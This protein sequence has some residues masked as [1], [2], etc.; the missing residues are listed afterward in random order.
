[1]T[2]KRAVVIPF[3]VPSEGRGLGIGLAALVHGFVQV[4]GQNVA[5]AQVHSR[6]PAS[7]GPATPQPVE[8]FVP[9]S[10][11]RDLAGAGNAPQG[12]AVV[13]TGA[14]EPP[15]DGRGAIQL[16]AFDARDGATRAAVESPLDGP[17]A[18]A[19]LIA[20]FEEL[21]GKIG[22]NLGAVKDIGDLEWDA[23]ESVLLAERFALHDPSRGG[24]NDR[25]AAMGHLGR[26]VFDAPDAR[27]PA[28][29]L[30]AMALEA[31]NSQPRDPKLAKA[32]LRALSRASEDA[33][34]NLDLSE[35][36]AAL[37]TRTGD[38]ASAERRLNEALT[39]APK[40]P[41]LYALLAETLRARGAMDAAMAAIESG[42]GAAPRDPVLENERGGLLALRGD[43]DDAARAWLGVLDRGMSPPAFA[44]AAA[45]A[46]RRRDTTLAQSLVDRALAVNDVPVD[47][48]RRAIQLALASEPDGIARATRV[49]KLARSIG[50]SQP[51][52]AWAALVLARATTQ[53][54]QKSEARDLLARVETHAPGTPMAAEAQRARFAIEEPDAALAIE[55]TL[56]A[57]GSAPAKDLEE[58][59]VR[60][61]RLAISHGG[62]LGWLAASVAERRAG[63]FLAAR[64]AANSALEI[65]PG[66]SPAHAELA[67][68]AI[69]LGDGAR[70]VLHAEKTLALEGEQP[71]LVALLARA[72]AAAGRRDEAIAVAERAARL[73]PN[74]EA[75]KRVAEDI[76]APP[77]QR[78]SWFASAGASV[79]K[80]L[81]R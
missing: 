42:L 10:A 80:L 51:D 15:T 81:R 23:L 63:R 79:K 64:E 44:N 39:R 62:W 4:D 40:R 29:R 2:D 67:S 21:C 37:E 52:D 33:P 74:D 75:L 35:A 70:A 60:A 13:L 58:I 28:G 68:V 36:M 71:R 12:I 59:A 20:A 57:A 49:A 78:A 66:C 17:H 18:G 69:G 56:R 53:L 14:F 11:W 72:L 48:A 31:A 16:L 43:F 9:P 47:V 61:R 27:F 65:A 1:M 22:A 6:A 30:A 32:A 41:G 76:A 19:M 55:A 45:I 34:L 26:A 38:P 25:L 7:D 5:L 73:D 50:S 8:A 46:M 24:P 3:G 54:G 77:K